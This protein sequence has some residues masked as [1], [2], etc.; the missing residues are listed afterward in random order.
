M[1]GSWMYASIILKTYHRLHRQ[2]QRSSKA[3]SL[4][5]C[6]K[7]CQIELTILTGFVFIST[8]NLLVMMKQRQSVKQAPKTYA[9]RGEPEDCQALPSSVFSTTYF[10]TGGHNV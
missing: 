6:K 3:V 7:N 10:Q 8:I 5:S 2:W 1:N 4:V 9:Y